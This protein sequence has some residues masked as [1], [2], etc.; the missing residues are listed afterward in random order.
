MLGNGRDWQRILMEGVKTP[1]MNKIMF[2]FSLIKVM[3]IPILLYLKNNIFGKLQRFSTVPASGPK[4]GPL[5][6]KSNF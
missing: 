2:I 4:I 6:T 3:S 5:C 1:R